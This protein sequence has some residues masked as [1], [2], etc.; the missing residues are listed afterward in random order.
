[1]EGNFFDA[2]EDIDAEW[3]RFFNSRMGWFTSMTQTPRFTKH[4]FDCTD[5][6]GRDVKVELKSRNHDI[7]KYSTL[8]IEVPKFEHLRS[9]ATDGTKALYINFLE[10]ERH[11]M[12]FDI[13]GMNPK[14]T[15]VSIYNPG[16]QQR[17]QVD[18]FELDIKEGY[19]YTHDAATDKFILKTW[20]D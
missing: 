4:D 16:F 7:G 1:M 15:S 13:E 18:R 2:M 20:D 9:M 8:F 5:I 3:F 14:M 10:D 17:Q 19:Y 12:V 6:L 11:V